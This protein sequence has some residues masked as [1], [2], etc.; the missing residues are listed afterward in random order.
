MSGVD[1]Q[2]IRHNR[3]GRD[4]CWVPDLENCW[5]SARMGSDPEVSCPWVANEPSVATVR[6]NF[7]PLIISAS[8]RK[9]MCRPPPRD[10]PAWVNAGGPTSWVPIRARRPEAHICA[11]RAAGSLGC[12]KSRATL[13]P[14]RPG[15]KGWDGS[16]T[17]V[18]SF[19]ASQWQADR[20]SRDVGRALLD[21]DIL[22]SVRP[23]RREPE[24][25]QPSLRARRAACSQGGIWLWAF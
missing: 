15:V 13:R 21:Q 14:L 8:P 7:P 18:S 9:S 6:F 10:A 12:Y 4:G 24:T 1:P 2:L 5:I 25:L 19:L 22:Q 17:K 11:G 3:W 23:V 16:R 20:A